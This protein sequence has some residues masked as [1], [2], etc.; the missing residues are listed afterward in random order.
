MAGYWK[1]VEAALD[2]EGFLRTGDVARMDEEGDVWI[3]DRAGDE[4]VSMGQVV[5]PGDVERVLLAHPAV[6]DVGV[7]GLAEGGAAFVVLARGA[8]TSE[9]ELIEHCRTHLTAPMVPTA[10]SFI[11]TLPKSSVG[12]LLRRQLR[13]AARGA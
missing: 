9:T 6:A 11:A 4:F 5:Y 12:K 3:V 10:I 7:I 13:E 8:T 1:S 2:P